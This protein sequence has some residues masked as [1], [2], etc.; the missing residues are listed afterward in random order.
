MPRVDDGVLRALRVS[1]RDGGYCSCEGLPLWT[2]FFAQVSERED[3][4]AVHADDQEE[5]LRQLGLLDAY[6]RGELRCWTCDKPV[7]S[8]GIGSIRLVEDQ[9][10]VG[11]GDLDCKPERRGE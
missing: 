9:I 1:A 10:R 7:K 3:I 11:C 4:H 2:I 6:Q 5:L 8:R